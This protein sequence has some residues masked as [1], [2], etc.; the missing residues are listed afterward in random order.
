MRL[1]LWD[2][3]LLFEDL[4]PGAALMLLMLLLASALLA[5]RCRAR[6]GRAPCA[7]ACGRCW[8]SMRCCSSTCCSSAAR[9]FGRRAGRNTAATPSTCARLRRS[10]RYARALR[11]GVIPEIAL[12]NLL[13]NLLLFVPAGVLLPLLFPPLGRLLPFVAVLL[14]LL[15]LVEAV[16]LLLR[17]GSCGRGRRDPEPFRRAGAWA[18][19]RLPPCKRRLAGLCRG[20]P[21][22]G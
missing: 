6:T 8:P 12:A 7:C 3:A 16:Q 17:C 1:P 10:C 5:A 18:C 9:A 15:V 11:R 19:Q 20:A 4:A 13:G 14:P 21:G 22:R 2:A